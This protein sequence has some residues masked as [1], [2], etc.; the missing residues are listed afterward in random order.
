MKFLIL[1][2]ICF[3]PFVFLGIIN[4]TK[5]IWAGRCGAPILQPFFNFTKLIKKSEVISETTSFIFRLS[6]AIQLATVLFALLLVPVPGQS[7]LLHFKADFVLFSYVLGLGK[8][9]L[10]LAAMDTGSSFEGMGASREVT[11][12]ALVEPAFFII[13]GTLSLITGQTSF[14]D[15]FQLLGNAESYSIII[16]VFCLISIFIMLLVEGSR[17][18]ADDPKTHLELTMIHE[19]MILDNSG[20]NLAFAL[21]ASALKMV[22]ITLLLANLLIPASVSSLLGF[23]L[24]LA[25]SFLTA[26]TIGLVESLIARLR[27]THVPQFI[28]IMTALALTCVAVVL[29]FQ[30]GGF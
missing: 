28:F 11:F 14:Q 4:R 29:F 1:I 25:V 30:H 10:V 27:M 15:I 21:Y 2:I 3:L 26:L 8:F 17:V 6:P 7:A 16:R 23:I 18:P 13:L 19:V 5:A 24:F 22:L 9:W 20:P 12:G